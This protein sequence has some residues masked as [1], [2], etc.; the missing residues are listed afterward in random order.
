[1]LEEEHVPVLDLNLITQIT[2][3]STHEYSKM[4]QGNKPGGQLMVVSV[5]INNI[6][7][8]ALIDT[9]CSA[10]VLLDPDFCEKASLCQKPAAVVRNV[11][12][13]DGESKVSIAKHVNDLDISVKNYSSKEKQCGVI[14][15][16]GV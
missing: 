10:R 11:V 14:K 7:A 12:L 13:G 3:P 15:L 4:S 8:T 2:A 9:G 5:L 16:G 1:M 6:G